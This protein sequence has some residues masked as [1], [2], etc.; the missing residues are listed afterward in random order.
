MNSARRDLCGGYPV[1]GIPTATLFCEGRFFSSHL[2]AVVCNHLLFL[3]KL[4]NFR[5]ITASPENRYLIKCNILKY[6]AFI[7]SGVIMNTGLR[8][9]LR[10]AG[11]PVDAAEPVRR[12]FGSRLILIVT[13]ALLPL[14]IVDV[15]QWLFVLSQIIWGSGMYIGISVASDKPDRR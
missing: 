14:L 1:T 15:P 8:Q 10:Y 6:S 12:Q 4:G 7:L 5:R 3:Q 13:V 9:V 11:V 2:V